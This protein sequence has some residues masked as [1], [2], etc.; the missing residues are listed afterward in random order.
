MGLSG[1]IIRRLMLLVPVLLGVTLLVFALAQLLSPLE[2]AGMLVR[3][4]RELRDLEEVVRKYGLEQPFYIQYWRWLVEV[5]QGNLGWSRVAGMPVLRAIFHYLPATLELALFAAPL[6]VLGGIYLGTL[7]ARH[8]DRPFDHLSRLLAIMGASLPAFWLGLML[9]MLFYGYIKGLFPP[10][11]LST[12]ISLY[13]NSPDFVRYTG[14]N[15]LDGLLN[16]DLRVTLDSLRHLLL[17]SMT[18]AVVNLAFIMRVMRAG[19]LEVLE[20]G[21]V[22][23]LLGLGF[24]EREVIRRARR[25]ALL[26]TLTVSGY[27]F[28]GLLNGAVL[29]EVVFDYRGLGWWAWQAALHFDMPSLLGFTLFSGF[30]FVTLNLVVDIAYA[31]LDPRVRPGG[32]VER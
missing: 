22:K 30:L 25:Q 24:G 4:F 15:F 12:E 29:T 11:R 18:L 1:Y 13:V 5:A 23:S 8:K 20:R 26:P 28:G 9:L 19:L 6:T 21:Y 27:V 3:D 17:P 32:M 16:G 31:W 2:R 14:L 7:A 10:E